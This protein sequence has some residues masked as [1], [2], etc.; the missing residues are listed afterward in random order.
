VTS[1]PE[2]IEPMA[3]TLT[4]ERFEGPEWIFEGKLDGIRLR[5]SAIG[6]LGV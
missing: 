5:I 2:W 3:A 1:L 6:R 4:Y